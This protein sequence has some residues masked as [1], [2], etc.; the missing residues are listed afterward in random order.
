[1]GN[2][3]GEYHFLKTGTWVGSFRSEYQY[4][5]ANLRQFQS[6]ALVTYPNGTM[7]SIADATQIQAG[8]HVINTSLNFGHGPTQYHLYID[9][10]TDA[11]PYLDFRRS[12]GFSAADTLRPRTIGVGVKTTF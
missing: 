10:L 6:L 7:G 12:P 11:A 4:R 1:M 5:G 9:N 2:G 3:Y 8:Y